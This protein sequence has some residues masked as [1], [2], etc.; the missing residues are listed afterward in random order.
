MRVRLSSAPGKAETFR[1]GACL[2]SAIKAASAWTPLRC[3]LGVIAGPV[4]AG[5]FPAGSASW[6]AF[7]VVALLYRTVGSRFRLAVIRNQQQLRRF[8]LE[9]S[10]ALRIGNGRQA[11]EDVSERPPPSPSI[12]AVT[13]AR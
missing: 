10:D 3:H 13:R 8:A 5:R 1:H 6:R 4:Q 11:G 12:I 9:F 2:P 7:A